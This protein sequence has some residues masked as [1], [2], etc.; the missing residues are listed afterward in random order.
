MFGSTEPEK[1]AAVALLSVFLLTAAAALLA[2]E[3]AAG[4]AVVAA[5]ALLFLLLFTTRLDAHLLGFLPFAGFGPG[6]IALA[7]AALPVGGFVAASAAIMLLRP[8][9][10]SSLLFLLAVVHLAVIATSIVR[11]WLYPGR[12]ARSAELQ[13]QVE[14]AAFLLL[15]AMLG[16]L[17][18]AALAWRMAMQYRR[19]RSLRWAVS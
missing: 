4:A 5:P 1:S 13:V 8:S 12:S 3:S 11:A 17:A 10:A 9:G 16:P 15:A 6:S 19:H 2:P 7:V 18:L 14:V